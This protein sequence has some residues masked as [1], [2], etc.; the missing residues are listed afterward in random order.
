MEGSRQP[1]DQSVTS[2]EET[3]FMSTH[4]RGHHSPVGS[5]GSAKRQEEN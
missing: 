4:I 1:K 2:P 3:V 5:G